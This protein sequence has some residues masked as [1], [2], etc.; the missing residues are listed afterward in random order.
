M[1]YC[2]WLLKYP[3]Y[4]LFIVFGHLRP[5]VFHVFDEVGHPFGLFSR[6]VELLFQVGLVAAK[7]F[8]F[9]SRFLTLLAHGLDVWTLLQAQQ[10]SFAL[11]VIVA[12]GLRRRFNS[13]ILFGN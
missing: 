1:I 5:F 7:L 2:H 3:I 9:S 10:R 8:L 12:P 6:F 11:N 4:L 13:F